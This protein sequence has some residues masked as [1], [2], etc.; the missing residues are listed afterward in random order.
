MSSKK[1]HG[2]FLSTCIFLIYILDILNPSSTPLKDNDKLLSSNHKS[3][4][5]RLH[6]LLPASSNLSKIAMCLYYKILGF[7]PPNTPPLYMNLPKNQNIFYDPVFVTRHEAICSS[8]AFHT[9]VNSGLK[10]YLPSSLLESYQSSETSEENTQNNKNL[11]N[12]A[13]PDFHSNCHELHIGSTL[14]PKNLKELIERSFSTVPSNSP[15]QASFHSVMPSP[16]LSYSTPNSHYFCSSTAL[17]AS[18]QCS[19]GILGTPLQNPCVLQE[20]NFN[21]Y[22]QNQIKSQNAL[23]CKLAQI[24]GKENEKAA[25]IAINQGLSQLKPFE[26]IKDRIICKEVTNIND[27]YQNKSPYPKQS[28]HDYYKNQ[29]L[30]LLNSPSLCD[31]QCHKSLHYYEEFSRQLTESQS[32]RLNNGMMLD[33]CSRI[34]NSIFVQGREE[35]NVNNTKIKS[36]NKKLITN[37]ISKRRGKTFSKKP[38]IKGKFTNLEEYIVYRKWQLDEE[39]IEIRPSWSKPIF[40]SNL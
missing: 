36:W 28:H 4:F 40:G 38:R 11:Y 39:N 33:S 23:I 1:L 2:T 7:E 26:V 13:S 31:L 10:G 9:S 22:Q 12:Q 18:N 30:N 15:F 19:S 20:K 35:R 21:S 25:E 24:S 8:P 16:F 14:Q 37:R 27:V 29:I 34:S 6:N 3:P 5:P 17:K 32:Q